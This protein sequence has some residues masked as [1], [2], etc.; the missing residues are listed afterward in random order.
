MRS[1][2]ID[3]RLIEGRDVGHF[4]IVGDVL[5]VRSKRTVIKRTDHLLFAEHLLNAVLAVPIVGLRITITPGS[6]LCSAR[7]WLTTTIR[8]IVSICSF[9]DTATY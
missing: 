1:D 9:A 4:E 3:I 5:R 7:H 6:F 2:V 8:T